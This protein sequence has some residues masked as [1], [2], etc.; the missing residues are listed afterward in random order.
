MLYCDWMIPSNFC[1]LYCWTFSMII[2]HKHITHEFWDD[3]HPD[4]HKSWSL[5]GSTG[6]LGPNHEPNG[7]F[8]Q[9]GFN[10]EW[11]YVQVITGSLPAFRRLSSQFPVPSPIFSQW[12]A[13]WASVKAFCFAWFKK[14]KQTVNLSPWFHYCDSTLGSLRLDII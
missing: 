5:A 14:K 3:N 7:D 2:I 10:G 1:K 8:V 4:P 11:G 13:R 6:G 9:I 12:S